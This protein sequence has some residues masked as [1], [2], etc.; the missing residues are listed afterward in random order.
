MVDKRGVFSAVSINENRAPIEGAGSYGRA[1]SYAYLVCLSDLTLCSY[2]YPYISVYR[3]R[4]YD[5]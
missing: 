4:A 1:F 2:V 5:P 3:T